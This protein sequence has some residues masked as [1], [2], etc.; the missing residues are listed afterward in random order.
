M[1]A[2]TVE[3][4][5][6]GGSLVPLDTKRAGLNRGTGGFASLQPASPEHVA[7]HEAGH[8]IMSLMFGHCIKSISIIKNRHAG[9]HG[10]VK[11]FSGEF[12]EEED[13]LIKLAG[14]VAELLYSDPLKLSFYSLGELFVKADHL[15]GVFKQRKGQSKITRVKVRNHANLCIEIMAEPDFRNAVNLLASR[16][17][18]HKYLCGHERVLRKK[19]CELWRIYRTGGI[20]VKHAKK[21]P[22]KATSQMIAR[23]IDSSMETNPRNRGM[24][25]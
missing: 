22:K 12:C 2:A 8:A 16:L 15:E 6:S 4:S 9:F 23:W 13:L 17:M 14:P 3:R 11:T 1:Q 18:K 19:D 21:S 5:A 7:H 24:S 10:L 20:R 25:S